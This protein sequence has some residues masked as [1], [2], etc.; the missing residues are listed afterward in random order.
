MASLKKVVTA[1]LTNAK[2]DAN[3][4]ITRPEAIKTLQFIFANH[5][6]TMARTTDAR[7]TS[8]GKWTKIYKEAEN[9]NTE[10]SAVGYGYGGLL[11]QV[12]DLFDLYIDRDS[13]GGTSITKTEQSAIQATI[14]KWF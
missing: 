2:R 4:N 10:Y 11:S 1:A 8:S 5:D 7:E 3:G 12:K 9:G 13:E 6:G 14:D